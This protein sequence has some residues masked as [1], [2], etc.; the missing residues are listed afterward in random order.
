MILYDGAPWQDREIETF[1]PGGADSED[2]NEGWNATWTGYYPRKF[3]DES[4]TR[5]SSTNISDPQWIYSRYGEI[6][7]N[8]A[9]SMFYLG[10]EDIARE[11]L[12]IVRSRPSVNMPP[13]TDSGESL[14]RRIQN[15]RRIELYME[16]HRWFDVRR[17]KIADIT[18]N[19]P[20]ER[21]SI[22]KNMLTGEKTYKIE[23]F[24]DRKFLERNYLVPIPQTE[25]DKNPFLTQNPGY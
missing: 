8:Y 7:L 4:I 3:I 9:E 16:E 23:V 15:E 12:N 20:A 6:L 14:E 5:P 24:E 2:G 22:S 18:E 25:I 11:Y 1:R 10:E 21:V 13:V 19:K 17:W